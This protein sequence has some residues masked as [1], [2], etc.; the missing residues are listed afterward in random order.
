LAVL[1]RR[2]ADTIASLVQGSLIGDHARVLF[3]GSILT[4]TYLVVMSPQLKL[5]YLSELSFLGSDYR[6]C[7]LVATFARLFINE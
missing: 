5:L 1:L 3:T 7:S 6:T 4:H 2:P